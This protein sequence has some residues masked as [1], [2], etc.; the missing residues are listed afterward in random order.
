MGLAPIVIGELYEAVAELAAQGIAVLVVEQFAR[1]ALAIADRAAIMLSGRIVR[2]GSPAEIAGE[3]EAAY[4][5]GSASRRSGRDGPGRN[6]VGRT[7]NGG[8]P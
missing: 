8:P 7:S 6:D 1:E 3:L 2:L 5:T 4:L